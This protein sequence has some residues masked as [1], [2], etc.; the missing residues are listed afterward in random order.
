MEKESLRMTAKQEAEKIELLAEVKK[1][2]FQ[3]CLD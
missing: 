2:K 1:S 3:K